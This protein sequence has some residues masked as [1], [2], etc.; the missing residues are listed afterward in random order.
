MDTDDNN[1]K[2]E[3]GTDSDTRDGAQAQTGRLR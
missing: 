3:D 2:E 1:D